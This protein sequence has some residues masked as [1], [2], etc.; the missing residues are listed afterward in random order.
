[1]NAGR[2]ALARAFVL[3]L[4]GLSCSTRVEAQEPPTRTSVPP[5]G[6]VRLDDAVRET[7]DHNLALAAERYGITV[8]DARIL[9]ARLRPN[10]VF[11]YNIMVPDSAIYDKNINPFENVFRTDVIVEGG[12][13][14][15]R[16]IE[17][18]EAARSVAELQLLN[19]MRTT[20]FDAESA[21]IDVVLAKVNLALARDS[22][23][24]FTN[25]VRVN[26]ERVRA[27]DLSQVELARS[28][29]AALQFQ[30]DVRQQQAKLVTA[31]SRLRTLMGRRIADP[32]EVSDDLRTDRP[33]I[34]L[35]MIQAAALRE[36]PDL[37][38]LRS[39]QA[40]SSA[41]VRL[42]VAQGKA[43]FTF[44]GEFHRQRAPLASGNQ[45]GGYVSVP[46]PIFNRNQ[47]EVERA[48]QEERQAEARIRALE[49]DVANEVR[50]A[51]EAY[52][53]S[54]DV[55]DTI[56]AQMLGEAQHVRTATEYS[57]RRG[58]ASF[59]EFL[60]SVR[61]FNETMQSYNQARA[62]YV[63][64]LYAI[65]AVSGAAVAGLAPRAVTP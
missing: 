30:N 57:Y 60:D 51:Y 5:P 31:Q 39:D 37:Q 65:D 42:Q 58:E 21:F 54:R 16:R 36:R 2:R 9:T 40:R 29:L 1:M 23:T 19:T 41:D 4:L 33:P 25:V 20:V 59:I 48:R 10:P 49:A 28:R 47:G 53:A 64:S 61:A 11:T 46:I 17:V 26:V 50:A 45:Y 18:A 52:T 44:S 22:L 3:V 15:E 7:L 55:I 6:T 38:A 27:G 34:D 32:L 24:A 8:A 14:R 35:A 62:D 56:E 63:R 43:D 12:G 13:K